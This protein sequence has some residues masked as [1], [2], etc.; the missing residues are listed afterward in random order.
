M[1]AELSGGVFCTFKKLFSILTVADSSYRIK[2]LCDCLDILQYN[3][4]HFKK[5]QMIFFEMN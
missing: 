5:R 3:V 2:I 4:I 1:N